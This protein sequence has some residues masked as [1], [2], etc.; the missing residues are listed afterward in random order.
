MLKT[1]FFDL[2]LEH[3]SNKVLVEDCW[4]EIFVHYNES[5]RKY[6]NFSHLEQLF[7]ILLSVKNEIDNWD[8]ILLSMFYHDLIYDVN[9]HDNEE[10]SANIAKIRL[11]QLKFPVKIIKKCIDIILASKKHHLSDDKDTNYFLDADLSILG[12]DWDKYNQYS[13]NIRIEYIIYPDNMFFEG[14]IL[15]L[16]KF[17]NQNNIFKTDFFKNKFEMIAQ[18]NISK[19]IEILENLMK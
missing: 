14:R 6:H 19:E 1:I 7:N 16:K 15:V 9:F 3:N 2:S 17:Q 10:Q 11:E 8:C 5:H 12:S 13:Q 18:Q 4:N